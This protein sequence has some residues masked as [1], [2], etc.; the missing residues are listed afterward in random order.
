MVDDARLIYEAAIKS[1]LPETLMP[2]VISLSGNVLRVGEEQVELENNHNIW[3]FGAGK[4]AASMA[5]VTERIL[6]NRVAGGIIIT[7]Y[8]HAL[9]LNKVQVYEA[10]HP[11]PDENS[12]MA[13]NKLLDYS[14][15]I[16]PT[17]IVIFLLSG[18]ASSLLLDVPEGLQ[19]ADVIS[20]NN[21]L[22]RSGAS[23]HQFNAIRKSISQ[24]KGGGLLR[25]FAPTRVFSLIVSDVPGDNI[26]E[27]GSAPT[28]MS[29]DSAEDSIS[30]LK[31]LNLWTVLSPRI[32]DYLLDKNNKKPGPETSPHSTVTN[33]LI[34]N[35]RIALEKAAEKAKTLGYMPYIHEGILEGESERVAET[36]LDE[37][38]SDKET[39]KRCYIFGSEST[40]KVNGNGK[41]G[42]CQH[43]ALSALH[44][45]EKIKP[46]V[47]FFAAGTDGQDGMMEVAGAYI[48]RNSFYIA[49]AKGIG[50]G[51]YL[52]NCDS[53]GFFAQIG[54]HVTV[55]PTH[56]NV[57]DVI[58][59]LKQ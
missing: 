7:K 35:N 29:H 15:R 18:G 10:G 20:L 46:D 5:Q 53:Y 27:I 4:A 39:G 56:T 12:L 40:V 14:S 58:M 51:A 54:G 28:L 33:L 57:M 50:P 17:D 55:G 41:G 34:G 22:L 23:I 19:L 45:L 16:A 2:N 24:V 49:Q 30:L 47:V 52:S 8:R 37:A 32:K 44:Q 3:I 21:S 1:V 6:G 25:Y 36:V 59:V 31:S 13:T 38:L 11:A 48:N 42:R 43:M 26:A 9:P